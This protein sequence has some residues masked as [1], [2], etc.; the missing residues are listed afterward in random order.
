ML[1][2]I[3]I[4]LLFNGCDSSIIFG[5]GG[6]GSTDVDEP[7]DQE[8]DITTTGGDT[9]IVPSVEIYFSYHE[10]SQLAYYFFEHV[11]IDSDEIDTSDWVGVFKGDVCVGSR[12]WACDGTC[13]V[14]IYGETSINDLTEGYM[15][16]GDLPSF[17][18]Y[19]ASEH[20]YYDAVPSEEIPWQ[21]LQTPVIELLLSQ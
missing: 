7:S 2:Y 11:L 20:M 10:S 19:D 5:G 18:I 17:K 1:S 8:Q 13:D 12:Q 14:P 16:P 4:V 15:L 3:L 9:I 21:H 6:N